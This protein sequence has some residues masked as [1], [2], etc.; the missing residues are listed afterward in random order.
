LRLKALADP[1]YISFK[2]F[3]IIFGIVQ[4]VTILFLVFVSVIKP[5]KKKKGQPK[6]Y[7]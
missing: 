4:S 5:W 6:K 3:N 2:N 7:T 1:S